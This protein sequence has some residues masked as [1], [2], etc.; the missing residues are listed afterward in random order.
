MLLKLL[1]A[2]G[3]KSVD[4]PLRRSHFSEASPA[5]LGL[6]GNHSSVISLVLFPSGDLE[7]CCFV[8]NYLLTSAFSH[9]P[10][11]LPSHPSSMRLVHDPPYLLKMQEQLCDREP[12]T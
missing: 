10:A 1:G 3:V 4:A 5:L 12:A 7:E 9:L 2:A 8:S 6:P 11:F